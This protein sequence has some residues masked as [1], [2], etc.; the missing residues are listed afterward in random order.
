MSAN[1]PCDAA[2]SS[3]YASVCSAACSCSTAWAAEL[4][5]VRVTPSGTVT[6]G[7]SARS[8]PDD[9]AERVGQRRTVRRAQL[10]DRDGEGVLDFEGAG[11]RVGHADAAHRVA[12]AV[13]QSAE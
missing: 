13:A 1:R 11:C 3:V 12:A 10:L 4:D 7:A 2:Y 8:V 6:A 5:S 9:R